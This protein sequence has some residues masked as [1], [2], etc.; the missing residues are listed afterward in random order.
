MRVCV[1]V[2]CV[3]GFSS[4]QAADYLRPSQRTHHCRSRCSSSGACCTH[5]GYWLWLIVL[6]TT[7][8]VW[9]VLLCSGAAAGAAASCLTNPLD[10]AKLRLQ[11]MSATQPACACVCRVVL[12]IFPAIQVQR[13]AEA[14]AA[15]TGVPNQP[16]PFAYRNIVHG[17][18]H[19]AKEA[20]P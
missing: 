1:C 3:A 16:P 10:M 2:R 17:V 18:S 5:G 13:G 11:V 4:N 15:A 8:A 14:T 9:L 20:P 12:T 7:C 6:F 19:I